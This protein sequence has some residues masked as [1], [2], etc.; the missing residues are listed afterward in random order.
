MKLY[1]VL[2]CVTLSLGNVPAT[3]AFSR[4]SPFYGQHNSSSNS[5][6]PQTRSWQSLSDNNEQQREDNESSISSWIYRMDRRRAL[7]QGAVMAATAGVM[8][9]PPVLRPAHAEITSDSHWPLWPALPVAPYARRKTLRREI[10]PHRVW[11]FDQIIG[12]YYVHVPIRMT[13]VAVDE[14]GSEESSTT[15]N[16]TSKRRGLVVYAPV[17]P[18]VECIRL[19]QEL[20]HEYGPVRGIILP[21]VAVE[22]KVHAGPFARKFPDADFYLTDRQ[23]SFPL[24]LPASFL[25]LPPWAQP[26]PMSS[27][28]QPNVLCPELEYQVL[29]V[30]PGPGSMYQDVALLHKPSKTLLVC[31]AI[32]AA[33]DEPPAILT[34]EP[35]YTRAL[36]FHARDSAKDDVVPD[37]PENRRKGWRRIVLLFNFFFPGSGTADLGLGPIFKALQTPRNPY[38]WGGWKPFSWKDTEELDFARYSNDGKP[39]I[40]PILQIILARGPDQVQEWLSVVT[41]WDF[42]TVVPAHLD[43]PL[44]LTPTE[45]AAA[46][47]FV[48][49]GKNEVRFCDEDVAFLRAAEEGP[50]NFSVFDSPLGVLR[51]KN[52]KCGL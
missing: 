32:L 40:L 21:S 14:Y 44:P 18:T 42:T 47:A 16:N 2:L 45:F 4:P 41:K 19:V 30:Q 25:G 12:I 31:D 9:T 20:E 5:H 27:S 6:R 24:P 23:Y 43:A 48:E 36:L 49:T 50:L 35:E 3:Y 51:G 13:V 52:G 29:T 8:A 46:F 11:T 37:T 33:T 15:D 28:S 26:L 7:W 34:A 39:T 1:L 38:G 17:A 10:I 22:H